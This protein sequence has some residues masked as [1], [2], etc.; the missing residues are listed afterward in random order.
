MPGGLKNLLPPIF[1]LGGG[2]GGGGGGRGVL[3]VQK[4]LHEIKYHFQG[5]VSNVGLF[6]AN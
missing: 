5:S 1:A 6:Y 2:G 4:R 3:L